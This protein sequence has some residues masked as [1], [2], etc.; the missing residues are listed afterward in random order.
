MSRA[1]WMD[2]IERTVRTA[3]QATAGAAL[4]FWIEA[5][6]FG[7]IDWN[8]LWQVCAY[9]AGLSFLMAI[10]GTRIANPDNGSVIEPPE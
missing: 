4:A 1:A 8:T 2:V 6:S 10:A 7:D 3:I 5:G 9:A